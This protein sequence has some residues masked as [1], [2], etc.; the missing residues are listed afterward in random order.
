M[1]IIIII[2]FI[3][4][5]LILF[6]A[7]FFYP[8]SVLFL[9][10]LLKKKYEGNQNYQPAISVL[11]SVYNEEDV[12]EK[13]IREIM[14]SD[15]PP[16][17][18]EILVGSDNSS[19]NSN[20][21]IQKLQID[22]PAVK[23]F[24]FSQRRGKALILNDLALMASGEIL[25]FCDANIQY[26]PNAIKNICSFYV[27]ENIGGVSGRQKLIENIELNQQVTLEKNYW[28]IESW[29]KQK[30]GMMGKLVGA[31]GG[32]YSL[33]KALYKP[34]PSGFPVMDDF[35]LSL[36]VI[37]QG[38]DF[39]YS[40]EAFASE[41][42]STRIKTEFNRKIRNNAID[43]S[44]LRTLGKL[45][46]PSAGLISYLIW[47]H[48]ILRWF[49]P[50]FLLLMFFSSMILAWS[51][52]FFATFFYIQIFFYGFSLLSY[53][54]INRFKRFNLFGLFFYFMLTNVA[55]FVGIVKFITQKQTPFW[56]S[57]P[58]T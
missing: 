41:F 56:Q 44:T 19:D 25:F 32:I 21:I 11:I 49:T 36:S 2:I 52:G 43:L 39:Y 8:L 38:K 15:Y 24:P 6:H 46:K 23:F 47:S 55:L 30:E 3:S 10:K 37:E 7:Y 40:S 45:L 4:S 14:K 42:V 9:S 26:D 29:L 18:M 27:N 58:R 50:I 34:I 28:E 13:T 57:T 12:I 54:A 16:N 1:Q 48:K 17:K 20:K 22:F 35:Y 53:L 51:S 31:N 33:R 5:F